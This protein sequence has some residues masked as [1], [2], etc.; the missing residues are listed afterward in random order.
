MKYNPTSNL[1]KLLIDYGYSKTAATAI[2][3]WY[4]T[5]ATFT[6]KPAIPN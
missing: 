6:P 5:T 1:F 4:T 3:N 2:E